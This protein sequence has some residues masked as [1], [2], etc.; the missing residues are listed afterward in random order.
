M[1][2]TLAEGLIHT[3][4]REASGH[5]LWIGIA[6]AALGF[7]AIV[8][9]IISTIV[10]TLLVGWVFLF[11]GALLLVGAFNIHG[12]GPFFGA[13]LI[14]LLTLISGLFLIV[15]PIAGALSLTILL[16]VV[17][18]IQGT[19]ELV[20]AFEHDIDSPPAHARAA[21]AQI[22]D[23]RYAE[24]PNSSHLGVFTHVDAVARELVD[25]FAAV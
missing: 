19:F 20:L 22:P 5:L 1:T 3:R 14:A 6:M 2:G 18:L 16:G 17:F 23:A 8:F 13:L 12:T 24:I 9:P 4:L 25:F 21:A 15:N 11:G 10:A 7:V